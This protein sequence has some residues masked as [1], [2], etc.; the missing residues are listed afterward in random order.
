MSGEYK[1]EQ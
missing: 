1:M